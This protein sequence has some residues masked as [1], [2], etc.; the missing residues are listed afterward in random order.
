ML[1]P[2]FEY[3]EP[4]KM[5]E[6]C[7][8]MVE[9]GPKVKALAG[10]TDLVVNM[11][12]GSVKPE[13]IVSL[14]GL[15]ELAAK[16]RD[17]KVVRIGSCVTIA[18]IASDPFV[19][20]ALPALSEGAENL[21]SPLVRNLATIGG[22]LVTARP[23]AD[24]PPPLMVLGASVILQKKGGRREIP[25]DG[26]FKGPGTTAIEQGELL[27]EILI[28]IPSP[29]SGS[30]YIKL[31]IRRALEISLVSV[32]SFVSLESAGGPIKE[33]RIAMGA[34]G[35]TPLRAPSAEQILLGE[36]PSPALFEKAAEAAS[37]DARPIDDFRGSADY[38]REMVRILTRR[39]LETA[40]KRAATA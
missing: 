12:K 36:R 27:R 14:A 8:L 6:A 15:A 4:K 16:K 28:R 37:R 21:G 34:V 26:F 18:D 20:A 25:L 2:R 30:S 33:A 40:L 19:R 31:G 7:R 11:K 24:M 10:G 29:F 1:L 9:L 39:S 13:Y 5:T 38:R 17:R 23:A 22:N 32:A 3:H 35:P